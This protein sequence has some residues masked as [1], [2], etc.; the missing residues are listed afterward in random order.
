MSSR[1]EDPLKM[2]CDKRVHER[3]K[4][5]HLISPA[6]KR[7]TS[8]AYFFLGGLVEDQVCREET[9]GRRRFISGNSR[10][11]G[12]VSAQPTCVKKYSC[13]HVQMVFRLQKCIV[14]VKHVL[15]HFR[16]RCFCVI[17]NF[18]HTRRTVGVQP[19]GTQRKFQHRVFF[20]DIGQTRRRRRPSFFTTCFR[21]WPPSFLSTG[22]LLRSGIGAQNLV[23]QH[24]CKPLNAHLVQAGLLE[25][26]RGRVHLFLKKIKCICL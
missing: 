20:A 24:D 8:A 22:K 15:F 2:V 23:A 19:L 3:R 12:V 21:F 18:P 14:R 16:R 1:L 6:F 4:R 5:R 7:V 13:H 9:I 10:C 11:L 25:V 26:Q 17:H